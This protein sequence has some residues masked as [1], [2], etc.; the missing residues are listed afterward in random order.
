MNQE[1]DGTSRASS[2]ISISKH[3]EVGDESGNYK[4]N[5]DERKDDKQLAIH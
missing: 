3:N 5:R 1:N 2:D 4:I